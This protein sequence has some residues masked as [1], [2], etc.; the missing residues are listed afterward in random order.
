VTPDVTTDVTSDDAQDEA[1]VTLLDLFEVERYSR[2]HPT[3]QGAYTDVRVACARHMNAVQELVRLL[4]Q[5]V[6]PAPD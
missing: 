3:D 2:A 5:V 4:D 6:A 1:M